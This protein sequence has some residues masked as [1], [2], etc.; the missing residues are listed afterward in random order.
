[1]PKKQLLVVGELNVDLIFNQI[2]GF[3]EI[4]KEIIA[5]N[6]TLTLGSSSAI[7]A[8]N[9]A[10]L[11]VNTSFFGAV[12]NDTNGTFIIQELQKK[13]VD[14]RFIKKY[15]NYQ[16]GAT[17][18]LNY[19]QDRAN[20][21][22][23]GAMEAVNI[24]DIP[25]F[26]L[27]E[28]Q[29]LHISN[30]FIQKNLKKDIVQI[31]KKA[32]EIGVT[33]SLDLQW[34]PLNEWDFNFKECLPYVDV[35]LPNKQE[36]LALTKANTLEEGLSK[37]TPFTNKIAVK[38]GEQGCLGIDKNQEIKISSLH[39]TNYVDSIGAGDSFNAGFIKKYLNGAS[40]KEC[41]EYGNL[42]GALNTTAAGG[43]TAFKNKEHINNTI[44]SIFKLDSIV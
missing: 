25:W 31:F 21:T 41:L 15:N 43:T 2:Q 16:T 11:G 24:L 44:K 19:S 18:V 20:I 35:F 8:A 12:G 37:I 36:L 34:D 29:H 22:Y 39:N 33:T 1:M 6:M 3:P 40:F 13:N 27:K 7:M 9:A 23:C 32:K 14:T 38:L 17:I 30:F 5:S 10:V 4:G 42:M 28:Y 26:E